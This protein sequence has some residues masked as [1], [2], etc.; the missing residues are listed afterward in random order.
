VSTL[1]VPDEPFGRSGFA[2]ARRESRATLRRSGLV[3]HAIAALGLIF[4]LAVAATA[5]SINIAR[6][7][8]ASPAIT[9]A[10]R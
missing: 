9:A 3:V 5:V 1:R 6:A 10:P 8:G 4:S 2:P 7:D